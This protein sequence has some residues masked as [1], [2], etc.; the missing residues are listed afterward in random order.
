MNLSFTPNGEGEVLNTTVLNAII[1]DSDT[2]SVMYT[3]ETPKYV[4][5]TLATTVTR[6]N[7]IDGS[8]R[9][10]F[11]ILWKGV[12]KPLDGVKVVLDGW[13]LEEIPVGEFLGSTR[14]S[15]T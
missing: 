9:F 2:G 8:T 6:W 3:T 13:S 5:G 4:G 1:R 14:G 15:T 11:R 12:R 7:Q 10:A